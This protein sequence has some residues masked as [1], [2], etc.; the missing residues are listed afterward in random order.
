MKLLLVG[1]VSNICVI[2][3]AIIIK[4]ALPE[5]SII[6]DCLGIASNDPFL[7]RNQ[8]ILWKIYI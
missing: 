8:L 3:N 7:N 6:I 2:S 5:A 4:A 1:V